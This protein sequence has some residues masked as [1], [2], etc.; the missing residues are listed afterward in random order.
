MNYN[1]MPHC[2]LI[3]SACCLFVFMT[4]LCGR[5]QQAPPTEVLTV[6]KIMQ[7][8]KWI[9]TS[10]S[11]PYWSADGQLLFFKWNPEQALSDSFYYVTREDLHPRKAPYALRQSNPSS[12]R[13]AYNTAHSSYTYDKDGDIFWAGS[14]NGVEKRI[15]N[16]VDKESKPAFSFRDTR[17]VYTKNDDLFAWDLAT[18]VTTQLTDFRFTVAPKKEF[19]Q[20]AQEKWLQE[21]QLQLFGVLRDRNRKKILGDSIDKANKP[22]ALK[23]IYLGDKKLSDLKISPDGRFITYASFTPAE[24]ARSS[25]VPSYVTES[26]F[27]RDIPSRTKVGGPAGQ[28]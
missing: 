27:T 26:G 20:N 25:I 4:T 10:P 6:E 14:R 3:R 2:A 1:P 28:L 17:I 21:D 16:T 5:A 22:A 19:P 13:V 8:P 24:G 23:P 11:S 18:G 7:D 15:T 9:G 12:D